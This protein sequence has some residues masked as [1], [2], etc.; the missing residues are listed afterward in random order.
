MVSYKVDNIISGY[1]IIN[2]IWVTNYLLMRNE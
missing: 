2:Q 1:I